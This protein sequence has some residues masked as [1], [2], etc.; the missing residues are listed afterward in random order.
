M[1]KLFALFV[2]GA[3]SALAQIHE[4]DLGAR[5][6]L[7]L[8]LAGDWKATS[9]NM[10]G[11]NELTL[12]PQRDGINASCHIEVTFPE[13]DRFDTKQRLKLRVEADC[14]AFAQQSVEGKA[15]GREF[16]VTSGYGYYCNFT[17]PNLRGNKPAPPGEFKVMTVG[18]IR[19]TPQILVDVQIMA[20]GFRD[21]PYQQLLG[22]IEGME[23]RPGRGR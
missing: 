4:L 6:K 7:V 10:A 18:K 13:V 12:A 1:K 2:L 22:A 21:E 5:G 20:D 14:Y 15:Y 17:D 16:Q 9:I 11:K 19:V 8:F 23:F 3:T